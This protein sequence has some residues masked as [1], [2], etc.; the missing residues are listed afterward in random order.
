[1]ILVKPTFSFGSSTGQ[2]NSAKQSSSLSSSG[3]L[4]GPTITSGPGGLS[5]GGSNAGNSSP[6]F[7]GGNTSI[8]NS[9][10]N[11]SGQGGNRE[12][13]APKSVSFSLNPTS[14]STAPMAASTGTYFG[15]IS[16]TSGSTEKSSAFGSVPSSTPSAS[17]GMFGSAHVTSGTST[18]NLFSTSTASNEKR[19]SSNSGISL[20]GL[21]KPTANL[22][23]EKSGNSAEVKSTGFTFG[24]NNPATA[25]S[26]AKRRDDKT[27]TNVSFTSSSA[28]TT[29]PAEAPTTSATNGNILGKPSVTLAD[30]ALDRKGLTNSTISSQKPTASNAAHSSLKNKSMDDIINKWTQA[31]TKYSTEFSCQAQEIS[32]WDRTL[33]E[34]GAKISQLFTET[35]QA[36]QTQIKVDQLLQYTIKQQDDLEA[37]LDFY[38]KQVDDILGPVTDIYGQG[39]VVSGDQSGSMVVH[40]PDQDR[41]RCFHQ[42]EKLNEELDTMGRNLSNM[43]EEINKTSTIVNKTNDDDPLS[44]IV[45]ILNAHL[46]SLQWIDVN[47][48]KL[49]DKINEAKALEG[50]TR[51]LLD[52]AGDFYL[53]RARFDR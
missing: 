39:A 49:Q 46:A 9:D 16:A 36:E 14:S 13:N 3:G 43:I 8:T 18:N 12:Q 48:N 29:T 33:V 20:T 5:F 31:L 1:M 47:A 19:D 21:D 51:E 34:N 53:Y 25:T 26:A 28:P 38:E 35:V 10:S 17:L 30:I 52:G 15:S 24:S 27:G 4:F 44:H 23:V 11:T 6:A 42:A 40:Q 41:E 50:H 45:R 37:M 7:V 22:A 2:V 32:E